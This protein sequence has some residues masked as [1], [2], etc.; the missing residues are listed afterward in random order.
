MGI[1][2]N[3]FWGRN[4]NEEGVLWM[5][6]RMKK[7]E[8]LIDLLFEGITCTLK[9]EVDAIYKVEELIDPRDGDL[10]FGLLWPVGQKTHI[11]IKAQPDNSNI[12]AQTLLHEILH[13]N[14]G[15]RK[16]EDDLF[17]QKMTD[18]LWDEFSESQ[19]RM[20]GDFIPEEISSETPESLIEDVE[21]VIETLPLQNETL[22]LLES[23]EEKSIL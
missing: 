23:G 8:K 3:I 5:A 18:L 9:K 13:I 4:M 14:F 17:I 22:K 19:K 1:V 7:W 20:L 6:D 16:K 10:L 2:K 21:E 15:H 12:E 11:Y